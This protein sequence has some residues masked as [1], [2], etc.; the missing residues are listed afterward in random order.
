VGSEVCVLCEFSSADEGRAVSSQWINP[1]SCSTNQFS[2]IVRGHLTASGFTM[3]VQWRAAVLE[4]D[5]YFHRNAWECPVVSYGE[6]ARVHHSYA[7]MA[8]NYAPMAPMHLVE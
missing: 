2:M 4:F 7:P 1:Q 3:L 5:S 6:A 8:H